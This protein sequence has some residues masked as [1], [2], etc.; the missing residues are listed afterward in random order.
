MK[1]R[2]LGVAL[3]VTMTATMLGA[4]AATVSAAEGG[5]TL[6]IGFSWSHKNDSLFYSFDE[7]LAKVMDETCKEHGYDAVEWVHVVAEDNADK[8]SSDISDLITQDCDVIVAYAFDNVAIASSAQECKDAGIPFVL[9]DRNMAEDAEPK[10]DLFIGL[11]TYNQ[12]YLAG[13]EFFQMLKDDGVEANSIISIM[14]ATND[15]N[16]LNREQGFTDAAKEFGLEIKQTVPSDWDAEKALTGFTAAF[17]ANPECNVVLIA[18]DFIVTAVQ[19]VLEANDAWYP[20][21]EEGHVYICSQDGFPTGIK[22][23]QDGYMDYSGMYNVDG[24]AENFASAIYEIIEGTYKGEAELYSDP[25]VVN[26]EDI[27]SLEL[28]GKNY[29]D[30]AE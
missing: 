23:M 12:A 24:M 11:D 8:Q 19:S 2:W 18:S 15:N 26:A 25:L 4:G 3:T 14:G 16:A 21:G 9:Y 22:F 6:K 27:E 5:E 13:K 1:K 30:E 7:S 20:K 28:W 29:M 10:A 17:Q